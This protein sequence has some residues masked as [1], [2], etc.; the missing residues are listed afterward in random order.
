MMY[1]NRT[2]ANR[3][4]KSTEDYNSND[5]DSMLAYMKEKGF[6]KPRDVWF[7]N[8][9]AFLDVSLSREW[10]KEIIDRAYPADAQWFINY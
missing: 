7:H 1:R 8:I 4:E 6:D 2:F 5:R 10:G 3:Y 9:H